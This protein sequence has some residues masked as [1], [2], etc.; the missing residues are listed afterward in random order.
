MFQLELDFW[1]INTLE[2]KFHDELVELFSS[3]PKDPILPEVLAKW[4]D[5]GPIDIVQWIEDKKV[6]V[7]YS[8]EIQSLRVVNV[9][10][11]GQVNSDNKYHGIGR[12]ISFGSMYEG[13][14]QNSKPDG[15]GRA[16]YGNGIIY[17]GYWRDGNHH[18]H[19]KRTFP[20]GRIEEGEFKNGEFLG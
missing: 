16:I 17:E 19:G 4:K 11:Q 2:S 7:D 8:Q 9:H 12:L 14:I 1:G 15:Y 5:V 3:A 13:F 20:D 18:G 10:Y 6:V